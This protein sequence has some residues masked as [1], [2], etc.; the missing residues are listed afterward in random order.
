LNPRDATYGSPGQILIRWYSFSNGTLHSPTVDSIR[1]VAGDAGKGPR[2]AISPAQDAKDRARATVCELSLIDN[3]AESGLII[4]GE[5]VRVVFD[6]VQR[7]V[8]DLP[9]PDVPVRKP[10]SSDP[11]DHE[12]Q[13]SAQLW[14][15]LV[16]RDC[17]YRTISLWI[18]IPC[19]LLPMQRASAPEGQSSRDHTAWYELCFEFYDGKALLTKLAVAAGR[20]THWVP[21]L[22]GGRSWVHDDH[23][24]PGGRIFD[25]KDL[26]SLRAK[27]SGYHLVIPAAAETL[28]LGFPRKPTIVLRSAAE[29][30]LGLEG[31]IEKGRIGPSPL[32]AC[33]EEISDGNV[34]LLSP[35]LS[36]R[37]VP[38]ASL[39]D[40]FLASSSPLSPISGFEL[41]QSQIHPAE[42]KFWNRWASKQRDDCPRPSG[43]SLIAKLNADQAATSFCSGWTKSSGDKLETNSVQPDLLFFLSFTGRPAFS[44]GAQEPQDFLG[45]DILTYA[46][47]D[48]NDLSSSGDIDGSPSFELR[49]RL[50]FTP[51]LEF[52]AELRHPLLRNLRGDPANFKTRISVTTLKSTN[53]E[54]PIYYPGICTIQLNLDSGSTYSEKN[55]AGADWYAL[56]ELEFRMA[57]SIAAGP[58]TDGI[59]VDL[60]PDSGV[61][62]QPYPGRACPASFAGWTIAPNAIRLGIADGRPTAPGYIPVAG[63][64]KVDEAPIILELREVPAQATTSV[65]SLSGSYICGLTARFAEGALASDQS[66]DYLGN[67]SW[68]RRLDAAE[69]VQSAIKPAYSD[70]PNSKDLKILYLD[71]LPFTIAVIETG[72]L[73]QSIGNNNEIAHWSSDQQVKGWVL[74][75]SGGNVTLIFPP[76]GVGE[77]AE[78][79]TS[80]RKG[81][82][83][84]GPYDSYY[85]DMEEKA[86][87]DFRFSPP[88]AVVLSGT[89]QQQ[90]F[91]AAPWN[92]RGLLNAFGANRLVGKPLNGAD[93][94]LLY[95]LRMKFDGLPYLRLAE[96][97][98]RLGG[99][100]GLLPSLQASDYDKV[101][102][103]KVQKA[104]ESKLRL[105][106]SRLAVYEIF[107]DRSADV[108]S[109]RTTGGLALQGKSTDQGGLKA[110]IRGAA[111][112][113]LRTS[114]LTRYQHEI[115]DF[116]RLAGSFAWAFESRLLYEALW[117]QR[118]PG[119][120]GPDVES[121]DATL[122]RVYFSALGGWGE[123]RASF[124]QGL[125]NI[126]MKVEMGRISEMR[127]EQIGRVSCVW[128]KAKLVTVFR[129]QSL[130]SA[131][132]GF[133]QDRLEGIAAVRKTEEYV[134]FLQSERSFPDSANKDP[135]LN[136]PLLSCNCSETIPVDSR[137]GEDIGDIGWLV[138][139]AKPGW[140]KNT[141]AEE[142]YSKPG[143]IYFVLRSLVN[144]IGVNAELLESEKLFFW[145]ETVP[146]DGADSD[147]W[148]ILL[149]IDGPDDIGLAEL[150]AGASRI[151][152]AD[153]AKTP[154]PARSQSAPSDLMPE[155]LEA[156]TFAVRLPPDA[157]AN[158]SGHL[159]SGA[160]VE[161]E[162]NS[163]TFFRRSG[164]ITSADA[165]QPVDALK[166]LD[167]SKATPK[168]TVLGAVSAIS[169]ALALVEQMAQTSTDALA[170]NKVSLKDIKGS[171]VASLLKNFPDPADPNNLP[172]K[173]KAFNIAPGII[174]SF[175]RNIAGLL[176]A[177]EQYI[178]KVSKPVNELST[179]LS[180]ISAILDKS[181]GEP[182]R[183]TLDK[184]RSL[185]LQTLSDESTWTD[186]NVDGAP[187]DKTAEEI[188]KEIKEVSSATTPGDLLRT[189][190]TNI[191]SQAQGSGEQ[192]LDGLTQLN[193]KK[194]I[195]AL[196]SDGKAKVEAGTESVIQEYLSRISTLT[197]DLNATG[198]GDWLADLGSA[199]FGALLKQLGKIADLASVRPDKRPKDW[200]KDLGKLLDAVD[201]SP[202]LI[203]VQTT[204]DELQKWSGDAA[205]SLNAPFQR[206]AVKLSTPAGSDIIFAIGQA[207]AAISSLGGKG[208]NPIASIEDA[209]TIFKKIELQTAITSLSQA[210]R[211]IK[212]ALQDF[213]ITLEPANSTGARLIETIAA[214][215]GR[216]L[217]ESAKD[218]LN[219]AQRDY[220]NLAKSLKDTYQNRLE[221][222]LS[223]AGNLEDVAAKADSIRNGIREEIQHF[224]GSVVRSL[225]PSLD[226]SSI[227]AVFRLARLSGTAP[228]VPSLSFTDMC[229]VGPELKAIEDQ[230]QVLADSVRSVAYN[231]Q[232]RELLDPAE[233][234]KVNV[235]QITQYLD[236]LPNLED[237]LN[238]LKLKATGLV[239]PLSLINDRLRSGVDAITGKN[240]SSLLP[241]FSGLKLEKL[242]G[243]IG[244]DP[245][246]ADRIDKAVVV[247]HSLDQAQM[248]A[249]VDAKVN[250]LSLSQ[251]IPM[252]SLGPLTLNLEGAVLN[253]HIHTDIDAQGHTSKQETA[254]I[255][256]DWSLSF[257]GTS[258]VTFVG[259]TLTSE[260]GSIHFN[261]DPNKMRLDGV[262]QTIS[263]QLK[264]FGMD[265]KNAAD[266]ARALLKE[267]LVVGYHFNLPPFDIGTGSPAILNVS[268]GA[269][270]ELEL[271]LAE[272]FFAVRVGANFARHDS[273]FAITI[274]FL[275]GGGWM[276]ASA[277]YRVYLEDKP[278]VL[279][280]SL[281]FAVSALAAGAVNLGPASG[282]VMVAFSLEFNCQFGNGVNQIS[283]SLSFLIAGHLTIFGWIGVN[284]VLELMLTYSG[285]GGLLGTGTLSVS[286]KISFFFTFSFSTGFTKQIA[287]GSGGS[288]AMAMPEL[289]SRPTYEIAG[290]EQ[291]A[292]RAAPARFG[293][294]YYV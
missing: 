199:P 187:P 49:S 275:G 51:T 12:G 31:E 61:Q 25:I 165:P 207:K 89:E 178:Q 226:T 140:A 216:N 60:L 98:A 202:E 35:L 241:D 40:P 255:L 289:S 238:E 279:V 102:W 293:T 266:D 242:L 291:A 144:P 287:S 227:D 191:L 240:L 217:D 64:I 273:P 3:K 200:T 272:K 123:G 66:S 73:W 290:L 251:T 52:D 94:E 81:G 158:I 176:S 47:E 54:H 250:Q 168:P 188:L 269:F 95:G 246:L 53:T 282:S 213:A 76:Q 222:L 48:A 75:G 131:Q 118:I 18:K 153:P 161:S 192:V 221:D 150:R 41:R 147:K 108:S 142:V 184:I 23:L 130:P 115:K 148:K 105:F 34:R 264:S 234:P 294:A 10:S 211:G 79:G 233:L 182:E 87:A 69:G 186:E 6:S 225:V 278:P 253:A 17:E 159:A 134:Q 163:V 232:P 270:M 194:R 72:S 67:L 218:W 127:V 285:S 21:L 175:E 172:D 114:M 169:N 195:D 8:N 42:F 164:S 96:I 261:L 231:F 65:L 20:D 111:R 257:G 167:L 132:F 22:R 170:S 15:R 121:L 126:A 179:K 274:W 288:Q 68:S 116:D 228:V 125:T 154:A 93:L 197:A 209:K 271:N 198:L 113:Q 185:A 277:E 181:T 137:W 230:V 37:F 77:E 7:R 281:S 58:S 39:S 129:R 235:T 171:V 36:R 244:I 56:G 112:D 160:D 276:E 205:N 97:L 59:V 5:D 24:L 215:L 177:P 212:E 143:K 245:A 78:K 292:G 117:E 38:L 33:W 109:D 135:L 11:A 119:D 254:S 45:F 106:E 46:A 43:Y 155:G 201:A 70:A 88:S 32:N 174:H 99:P 82:P 157:K 189:F 183:E 219:G 224:S 280:T 237:R 30:I 29:E 268:L 122:S 149:G 223:S 256:A 90:S 16:T 50:L 110:W 259:T 27:L 258:V 104:W 57:S 84:L 26:S 62:G 86:R 107:D 85:Y 1:P 138:P 260:N 55:D 283:F 139:L 91:G 203:S 151:N 103:E 156:F 145:T 267:D 2:F 74:A 120:Q 101:H 136:G 229:P 100:I 243:P 4:R 19:L 9:A 263:D 44:G 166:S 28:S 83:P 14:R 262:L 249:S 286:V 208:A 239:R 265:L 128:N 180:Q 13:R 190:R 247:T 63:G 210:D 248:R 152:T 124:R 236:H 133:Q 284:V 162:V 196:V 92:L 71:R 193:L 146:A 252:F 220:A 173:L 214:D 206:L 141:P 204:I 80:P